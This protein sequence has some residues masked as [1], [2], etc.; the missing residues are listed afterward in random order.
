MTQASKTT[1]TV[2]AAVLGLAFAAATPFSAAA[3][4]EV[5]LDPSTGKAQVNAELM[6]ALAQL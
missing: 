4:P 3:C 1:R 5:T 6:A 2:A